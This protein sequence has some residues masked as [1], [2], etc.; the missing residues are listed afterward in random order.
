VKEWKNTIVM[1]TTPI[2][3]TIA[4]IDGS[5]LQIALVT[6]Q[7]N[8]LLGTVTDGDVRRGL[9]R[10]ISL[11][12]ETGKIMNKNPT[13]VRIGED[14]TVIFTLMK[15]KGLHQVPIVDDFGC[16][17]GI[18]IL[19]NFLVRTTRNNWVV[20][21]AGGLGTRLAPLTEKCPKPMLSVGNKPILE[22]I[23]D[24]FV[25]QGF[26]RFYFCVN[27][28]AEMVTEYFGDGSRWGVEIIYIHEP[29]KL[30]TAGALSL[31]STKPDQPMIVMNGDLLTNLN[32]DQLLSFHKQNESKVTMCIREYDFQVPYGVVTVDNHVV[33]GIDEKPV[34]KFFVNA[35]IYVLDPT[36]LEHIPRNIYFDM[37]SLFEKLLQSHYEVAAFPIREYWLD[38]GRIDDL[39]KA[40]AEFTGGMQ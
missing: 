7:N 26:R 14:R 18:E 6:N 12:D 13:I 35:G 29:R 39:E 3:E 1:E 21:M 22:N 10:G 30:G 25:A 31:L 2:R 32:F 11:T 15:D 9:L 16:V 4:R 38:V 28:K 27:Y 37:P 17:V 20:L 5:S 33:V 40:A 36:T 23:L 34:Q 19:D 24:G 8:R